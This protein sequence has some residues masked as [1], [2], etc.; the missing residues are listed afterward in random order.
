[1][2]VLQLYHMVILQSP[3]KTTTSTT[4]T[5]TTPSCD[6]TRRTSR[7]E[8]IVGA[9]GLTRFRR[10]PDIS[11]ASMRASKIRRSPVKGTAQE[12]RSRANPNRQNNDRQP[13]TSDHSIQHQCQPVVFL[14]APVNLRFLLTL[15]GDIERNP[16]P[17]TSSVPAPAPCPAD[18]SLQDPTPAPAQ[19]EVVAEAPAEAAAETTVTPAVAPGKP[20][21]DACGKP[22]YSKNPFRCAERHCTSVCHVKK[23]CSVFGR[24]KKHVTWRCK[25]HDPTSPCPTDP[26]SNDPS[27][28]GRIS[29]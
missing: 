26:P 19:A 21:C 9:H 25:S 28:S 14:G 5:T 29:C 17:T 23:E 11:Q 22:C 2:M 24:W 16:G 7:Q 20:V 12:V 6:T 8:P 10:E 27:P 1:M 13:T 3:I 15:A 18:P 4:T